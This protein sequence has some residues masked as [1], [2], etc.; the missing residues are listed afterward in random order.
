MRD[1][2]LVVFIVVSRVASDAGSPELLR[3]LTCPIR[4][5]S[6]LDAAEAAKA[7]GNAASFLTSLR[8]AFATVFILC[9]SSHGKTA[10]WSTPV[11]AA[12]QSRIGALRI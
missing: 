9:P 12:C 3:Q 4:P 6:P 2:L 11:N 7:D 8:L 10:G 1:A 5:S